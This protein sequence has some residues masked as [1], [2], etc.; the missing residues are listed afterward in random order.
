MHIVFA[1]IYLYKKKIVIIIAII[2]K[3]PAV[4]PQTPIVV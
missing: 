2:G 3:P 4:Q 1:F